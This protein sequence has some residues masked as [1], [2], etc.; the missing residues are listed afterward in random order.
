MDC[1]GSEISQYLHY[2]KAFLEDYDIEFITLNDYVLNYNKFYNNTKLDDEHIMTLQNADILILQVIEK[3]RGFL[4]NSEVIKFCKQ[5]CKIIKIPHYRNSIYEYKLI[6]NKSNK[7][8]ILDWWHKGKNSWNFP[9]KINDINNVNE[10]MEII[11]NEIDVMNNFPHDKKEMLNSMN[12]K[13]NEFKKIDNLS[14]I[15]MLDFYNNNYKKYRLFMGRSY[16]SSIFFF[17]LTNR[18]LSEL[19]YSVNTTFIDSHFAQNTWDPIPDYW[20]KFCNFTFD[21]T[22]YVYGNIPVTEC[23]W[24]YI[25][26]YTE[27]PFVSRDINLKILQKIR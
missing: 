5:D 8:D 18:I 14:D 19:H 23:E 20:Y 9:N 12:L 21:N 25:L 24:Y 6:E 4:N 27:K 7:Y 17:E 16:P 10:T 3:D 13:I 1:H 26:L 22:Y 2:N 15:K 11:Q